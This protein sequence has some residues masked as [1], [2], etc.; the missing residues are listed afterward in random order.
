MQRRG[1]RGGKEVGRPPSTTM[2]RPIIVSYPQHPHHREPRLDDE[3]RR[4]HGQ[5]GEPDEAQV[6]GD[7]V[8]ELGEEGEGVASAAA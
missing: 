1:G 8:P 3:R 6:R 5:L 2:H 7:A 4:A